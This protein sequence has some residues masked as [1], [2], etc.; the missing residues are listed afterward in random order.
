MN[1]LF[2]RHGEVLNPKNLHYSNLPGFGLSKLGI[3]QAKK[4]GDL[5][6][7][8]FQIK[9]ILTSPLLRA[10]QTAEIV[11]SFTNVEIEISNNLIEWS[12]PINWTGRTLKEIQTTAEFM[13]YKNSPESL[14]STNESFMDL[15]QRIA[16]LQMEIRNCL[17]V[18]H[19]DTIR[20]Y[21]FYQLSENKFNNQKPD[22]CEIQYLDGK[23]F[24]NLCI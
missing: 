9:K 10:R 15:F 16:V 12:G 21:F 19:Q 7:K 14:M 2:L 17:F 18:S 20:S 8:N 5:I 11:N 23:H 22:H 13:V 24:K 3:H 4:A 1:N 6:N